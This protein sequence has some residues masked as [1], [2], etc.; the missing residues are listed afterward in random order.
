MLREAVEYLA[1]PASQEARRLG[2]LAEAVALGARYRRR[3]RDWM[4][5]VAACH[6]FV[7]KAVAAAPAGGQLLVAGSGLL[8][9]LPL[10]HLA[11]RFSR[12]VLADMV[13]LLPVRL[14]TRRLANVELADTDVTGMLAPL[15]RWLDRPAGPLPEPP[16][17][18]AFVGAGF[19][20]VLSANLLSQLPVLPLEAI[21][22]RAPQVT[23]SAREA[24][25]QMLVTRHL[26]WLS[27]VAPRAAAYTD[28]AG[29]WFESGQAGRQPQDRQPVERED[30]AWGVDLPPP[31]TCWTWD[32]APAPEQDPA[33]D[34]CLTV[35]AWADIN[36]SRGA[37]RATT[38]AT[39]PGVSAAA[40][41]AGDR[42]DR[43]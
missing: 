10:D 38:S 19:D 12:V 31:D 7:I 17:P 13:H 18:D 42:G 39:N 1:T 6:A 30:S 8:I 35:G 27:R 22:Q 23:D 37:S 9:E 24:M 3:R 40:D 25:A 36:A 20:M 11:A 28:I 34:L 21:E 5:H 15:A 4:A 29:L 14:R 43:R 33:R 2:Y 32:I 26:D 41:P 16:G